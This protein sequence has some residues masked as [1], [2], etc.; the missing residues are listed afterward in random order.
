LCSTLVAERVE[1]KVQNRWTTKQIWEET[2]LELKRLEED[3]QRAHIS[4]NQSGS[5]YG[6]STQSRPIDNPPVINRVELR[7]KE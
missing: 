4:Y 5:K 1:H 2:D 6:S 3:I 7:A